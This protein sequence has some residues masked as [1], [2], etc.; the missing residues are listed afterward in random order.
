MRTRPILAAVLVS[1]TVA[2]LFFM[3]QAFAADQRAPA[4]WG[5]ACQ[6]AGGTAAAAAASGPGAPGSTSGAT[7]GTGFSEG[8]IS[9]NSATA[10]ANAM[11]IARRNG[12]PGATGVAAV[13]PLTRI[14][15]VYPGISPANGTSN[16]NGQSGDTYLEVLQA[17]GRLVTPVPQ[18]AAVYA[19]PAVYPS[20][21]ALGMTDCLNMASA[22]GQPLSVCQ[23]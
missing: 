7:T 18:A 5:E 10:D 1:Q 6:V 11:L 15:P 22:Q 3:S 8:S 9:T 16:A 23:R 13:M 2:G 17:Q 14:G 20:S 12:D 21:A 19:P 4:K